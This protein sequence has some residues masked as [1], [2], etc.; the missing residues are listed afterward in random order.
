MVAC[1]VVKTRTGKIPTNP[2][3]VNQDTYSTLR[4]FMNVKN[5]WFFG[6]FDGHGVN[7]HMVSD[8]LK[9]QLPGMEDSR[10]FV[11]SKFGASGCRKSE[12]SS[13]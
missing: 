10:R 3:K 5:F 6:V 13:C 11:G 7:G 2:H 8:Y 9:K 1:Y 12:E 4:N